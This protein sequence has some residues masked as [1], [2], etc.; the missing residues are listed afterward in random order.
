[1]NSKYKRPIVHP[2]II[3]GMKTPAGT[4][5]PYVTTK[6]KYHNAK[7]ILKFQTISMPASPSSSASAMISGYLKNWRIVPPSV[8]KIKVASGE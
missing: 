2:M 1:M 8:L 4:H 5:K 3:P 7:Y 6:K